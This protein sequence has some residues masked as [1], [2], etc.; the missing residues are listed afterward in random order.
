MFVF[1]SFIELLRRFSYSSILTRK[2]DRQ[3]KSNHDSVFLQNKSQSSL[4]G[5]IFPPTEKIV[6]FLLKDFDVHIK[7]CSTIYAHDLERDTYRSF[8][9]LF[10]SY[11]T[12]NI[13]MDFSH[14]KKEEQGKS[15]TH[16]PHH[17]LSNSL[18]Y[19][20]ST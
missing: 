9:H 16:T 12:S 19:T 14:L 5:N 20:I 7:V 15:H 3:N 11:C 4:A 13:S 17:T 8:I 2:N 18:V 6:N 10:C 1:L